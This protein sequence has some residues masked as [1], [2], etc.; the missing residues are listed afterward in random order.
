MT[1]QAYVENGQIVLPEPL[2]VP[3][4]TKVEV[5]VS[6]STAEEAAETKTPTL[7]ERLQRSVGSADYLP[8]DASQNVDH[9]LYGKPKQ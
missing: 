1:I 3:N 8:A 5:M 2:K 7:L 9:Y 4:G 6:K